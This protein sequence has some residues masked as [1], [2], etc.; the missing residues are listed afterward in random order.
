[1]FAQI[2]PDEIPEVPQQKFL[3]RGNKEEEGKQYDNKAKFWDT[4][5]TFFKNQMLY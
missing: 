2:R 5:S 3:Y 1:M 4:W